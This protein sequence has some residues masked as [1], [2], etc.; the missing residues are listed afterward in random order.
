VRR[1]TWKDVIGYE[2][3]Y[4]V[5]NKGQVKRVAGGKGAV[6]DRILKPTPNGTGYLGVG[7]CR[8][9]KRKQML[10]HRLVAEAFFGPPPS[11][12]HEVNH[13]SGNKTDNRVENLEWVTHSENGRYA[14]RVL[15][16]RV[17]GV[18][19]EKHGQSKLTPHKIKEIR[20]LYA[21]GNY[22]QRELG[23]MFGTH[24]TNIGLIVRHEAWDHIP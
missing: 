21:T 23:R 3:I 14:F 9:G 8:D 24:Q 4:Q 7:L 17:G 13:K 11:P 2:G 20:R 1:E 10:V 19:G 15:G 18:K 12:D 5:S 16:K 6:L 22:S